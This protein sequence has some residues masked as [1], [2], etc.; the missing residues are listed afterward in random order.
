MTGMKVSDAGDMH[1]RVEDPQFAWNNQTFQL[2]TSKR[3][4]AVEK[5]GNAPTATTIS[6]QGLTSLLYG[7][8]SLEQIEALD[9]LRGEK[10]NLLSRWFTP[11]IPWLIEDF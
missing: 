6:I 2:S 3:R 7:T 1:L 5:L 9:W 11:G 10:H 8:L 4:L